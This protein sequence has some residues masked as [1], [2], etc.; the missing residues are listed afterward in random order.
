MTNG[1]PLTA[2]DPATASDVFRKK[3]RRL[4]L[5]P[6]WLCVSFMVV[7]PCSG[8]ATAPSMRPFTR[9]IQNEN[10]AVV[11]GLAARFA[12]QKTGS[13]SKRSA[14]K[15]SRSQSR[16]RPTARPPNETAAANPGLARA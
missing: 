13:L 5:V 7:P 10:P 12:I 16:E 15:E 11:D 3:V 14:Q 2:A 9:P 6:S 8:S 1:N 4:T